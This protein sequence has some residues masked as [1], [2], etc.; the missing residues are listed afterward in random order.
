M[1]KM[2]NA[3]NVVR[4]DKGINHSR[5][6][7]LWGMGSDKGMGVSRV[8]IEIFL[9]HQARN[10]SKNTAR[11]IEIEIRFDSVRPENEAFLHIHLQSQSIILPLHKK[12]K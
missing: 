3:F 12:D 5:M 2:A 9:V 11:T 10:C 8:F 7:F 1:T 4:P 6:I